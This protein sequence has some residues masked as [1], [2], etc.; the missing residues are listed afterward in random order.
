MFFN[1]TPKRDP[2]K[3]FWRRRFRRTLKTLLITWI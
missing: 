1:K 2:P 3:V